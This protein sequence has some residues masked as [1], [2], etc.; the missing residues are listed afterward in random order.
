MNVI[1]G[2]SRPPHITKTCTELDIAG[3]PDDNRRVL[4]VLA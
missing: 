1:Y 4:A 2:P 3:M